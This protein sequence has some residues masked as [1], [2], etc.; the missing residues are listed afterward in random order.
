MQICDILNTSL[1]KVGLSS[2]NKYDV[3]DELISLFVDNGL[4]DDKASAMEAVVTREEKMSTGIAPYVGIPH[5]KVP[6]VK[7]VLIALGISRDGIEYDSLDGL[8]VKVVFLVLS[9]TGNPGPHLRVLSRISNLIK[10]SSFVESMIGAA[11]SSQVLSLIS[12]Q[13]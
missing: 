10:S 7:D 8:P 13:E 5:G 4:L 3:F 2:S 6:E 9:E 1:I 12:E 11:D